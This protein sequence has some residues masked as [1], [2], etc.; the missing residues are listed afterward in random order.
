V[1]WDWLKI[2]VRNF[3]MFCGVDIGL[4][5]RIPLDVLHEGPDFTELGIISDGLLGHFFSVLENLCA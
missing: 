1:F 5:D 3:D 2:H 4:R